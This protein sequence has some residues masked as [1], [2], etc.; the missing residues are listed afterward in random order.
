MKISSRRIY[1]TDGLEL[2]GLLYE[3]EIKTSSVVVHVHGMAGNFY[4]NIFLDYLAK[5]LTDQGIAF[6]TFNNRGC[7]SFKDL[8]RIMEGKRSY[9][10]MGNA[11]ENFED[12]I[13]D[14]SSAINMMAKEGFSK[15]QLSGHSLG[16]AKVSYYLAETADSRI[17]SVLL[18]SPA[19]ML[20][21]VRVDEKRFEKD[22]EE[23]ILLTKAGKGNELISHQVWD[24]YPLSAYTYLSLFGNASKAAIFNF[25]DP[26]DML[27]VL[28]RITQPMSTIMGRKDDALVV[29]I[30]E[31]MSRIEKAA[32][33]SSHVETKI[34]GDAN[35]SYTGDEQNL[36]DEILRWV[37]KNN[38]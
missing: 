12:C 35:H 27:E 14:I 19:D 34:L 20:G 3:P 26:S 17:N 1:T 21:L 25:Y 24:E 10:R 4:E 5:T 33:S 23:A 6:F 8:P 37:K 32:K 2:F 22:N 13:L 11:Y 7:E 18:L 28:A 29:S 9:A 38:G 30:E 16:C 36:A 15:I 31:T